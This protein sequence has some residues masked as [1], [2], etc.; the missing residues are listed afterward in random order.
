MAVAPGLSDTVTLSDA[1]LD[2]KLLELGVPQLSASV[3]QLRQ[4]K[5]G[6]RHPSP[7]YGPPRPWAPAQRP[8]IRLCKLIFHICLF[9]PHLVKF[10]AN[11]MHFN[12]T[13]KDYDSDNQHSHQSTPT[14]GLQGWAGCKP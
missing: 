7:W 3:E 9:C 5:L 8:T 2:K 12:T 10:L 13:C 6:G 11:T 4:Q 14:T 1:A